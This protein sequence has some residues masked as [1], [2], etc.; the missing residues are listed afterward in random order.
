M[1]PGV[2]TEAQ[3]PPERVPPAA[4]PT[5]LVA[6]NVTIATAAARARRVDFR[7]TIDAD[8]TTAFYEETML[9]LP[10]YRMWTGISISIAGRGGGT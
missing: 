1:R 8:M 4:S 6:T 9:S 2:A 10:R 3:L 7:I 5:E